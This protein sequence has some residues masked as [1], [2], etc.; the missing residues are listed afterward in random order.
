MI[1]KD[2]EKS[3]SQC[4]LLCSAMNVTKAT[5][6]WYKGN[7][8][9]STSVSDLNNSVSLL[10]EV[11]DQDFNDYS[12]VLNNSIS[13]QTK[14]LNITELG[15]PCHVSGESILDVVHLQLFFW[16]C[17]M[18]LTT[19]SLS[20]TEAG[21]GLLGLGLG[22]GLLGLGLLRS[23]VLDGVVTNWSRC[24]NPGRNGKYNLQLILYC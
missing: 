22:L 13:N 2:S 14:H 20:M 8:L 19:V 24:R 11:N 9:I 6:C 4:V 18:A 5:L 16:H 15:Q 3:S 7:S 12:C 21:L 1:V 10:L 17:S 23:L